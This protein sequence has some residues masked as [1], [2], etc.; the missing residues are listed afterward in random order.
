NCQKSDW[1][2]TDDCYRFARLDRC[3][4]EGMQGNRERL[5]QSGF[6]ERHLGRDG[7]KVDRWQ[8]DQFT[9][10]ARMVRVTEKAKGRAHVVVTAQTELAVITVKGRLKCTAV[11]RSESGNATAHLHDPSCRLVPEYHGVDIRSAAYSALGVGMQ[12]GSA[13]S[14]SLDPDLHFA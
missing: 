6:F 13:D 5:G 7:K 12:I 8:V 4:A 9:E 11:A 3:Q 2:R 14:Y 10:K 1:S